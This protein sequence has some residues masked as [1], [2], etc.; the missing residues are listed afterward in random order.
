M[1]PDANQSLERIL[2]SAIVVFWADL[3]RGGAQTG[4]IHIEYG[5]STSGTLDYLRFLSSISRGHW[6]LVGEY[7]ME[8]S[9][10]HAA[11]FRFENGYQSEGLLHLVQLMMQHQAAFSLPQDR[12][13]QGLLQ[14]STPTREEAAAATTSVDEALERL[15]SRF[16]EPS[17]GLKA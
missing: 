12:G 7:W 10:Y 16:A 14:I 6:F 5:F 2:E 1:K 15:D 17:A 4:L 13:R 11:G 8:T 9:E 3:M